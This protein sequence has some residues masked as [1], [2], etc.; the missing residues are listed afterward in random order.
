MVGTDGAQQLEPVDIGQ[1]DIEHGEVEILLQDGLGS[2]GAGIRKGHLIAFVAQ[3][4]AHEVGNRLLVID[5][6][7]MG[8]HRMFSFRHILIIAR[9]RPVH[10]MRTRA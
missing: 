6:E 2:L 9:L 4:N 3:V 5:N 7:D 10:D 1:H 8:I